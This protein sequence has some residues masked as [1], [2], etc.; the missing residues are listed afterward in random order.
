MAVLLM[1]FFAGTILGGYLL[2]CRLDQ[3]IDRGGFVREPE[4]ATEKEI[5]LYGDRKT[6]TEIGRALDDAAITYDCT[7]EPAIRG[8]TTYHWIGACSGDDLDNILI[9]L[10][11]KRK[12]HQIRTI[13]KCNDRTYETIFQQTGVAVILPNE[14]A[15]YRI[16]A[17]LKG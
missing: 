8:S 12:N 13:A 15:A 4:A 16:L 6:I 11:A 3:F 17:C 10:S 14:V 1:V 2:M 7:T 9:C 5:L